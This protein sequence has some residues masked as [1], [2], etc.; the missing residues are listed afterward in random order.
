MSLPAHPLEPIPELTRRIAQASFPKG[1]LAMQLRDALGPIYEDADFADLFPKRGR[2][3][4]APWRLA[5]VTV[6]QALENLS[7]RQAAE[8]VRARLD[9]KYALSLPLDDEGFDASILTDFR[10]R[11]VTHAAQDRLLEPILRVCRE[12]G[13]LKAGGKQRT[14]S[15]FVLANVRGLSSLESVGEGLRTAL[16]EIAEVA[17]DWLLEIVSP[18]WFDRYVHRFELQRLPKGEQ[19]KE[20]L[21]RQVGEDSWHL[22]QA[23]RGEQVPHSVQACRSLA[24]LQQVWQQHFEWVEGRIRWRDGPAVENAQRVI[25]PYETDARASRKRETDWVGYKVHLT[26]TCGEEEAVQL[27]VQAEITPATEQDSEETMP[28][29]DDLQARDLVPEVRLAES[30]YVSGEVLVRHAELGIELVGPLKQE[31]GWQHATG[32][33][34]SAFQVDWDKQQVRCPQGHLSQNWCPGRHNRG[35]EV[36]W[37]RFSAVTCQACPVKELCTKREKHT[38]RILTLSPQPIHEARSRRRTEQA[39]PAFQQRYGL[40]AGIEGTL[41]EGVRSHGLRRAR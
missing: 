18:D 2:A 16:N 6:L 10:Q 39:T 36:I 34:V 33:G 1:T 37:V 23:A 30:G 15:T 24:V 11:L 14:D 27:I 4:E 35:E 13:W 41:S 20:E 28:L 9:W 31:G 38:G 19:A 25:S 26:E 7:D 29:L 21:R 5:M 32:Y 40:R 22:L 3:A 17:P 8:M 12:R